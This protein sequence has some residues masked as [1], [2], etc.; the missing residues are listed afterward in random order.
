MGAWVLKSRIFDASCS[1]SS[2]NRGLHEFPIFLDILYGSSE[3]ASVMVLLQMMPKVPGFR[4]RDRSC[5]TWEAYLRRKIR[6]FS[7][8]HEPCSQS[9]RARKEQ[10]CYSSTI[11]KQSTKKVSTNE[12]LLSRQS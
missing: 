6:G 4:Y 2:W 5:S 3:W 1:T 11:S 9:H 12:Y 8:R 10:S 7:V